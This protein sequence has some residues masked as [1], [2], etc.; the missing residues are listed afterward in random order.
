MNATRIN[1]TDCSHDS[2][3]R[4]RAWC[5][6]NRRNVV[7]AAQAAYMTLWTVQTPSHD[8]Y[9]TYYALVDDVRYCLGG[10]LREAYELVENGPVL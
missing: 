4:G 3:A 6:D 7:R 9:D 5:R 1:H 8:D 10:T 2:T